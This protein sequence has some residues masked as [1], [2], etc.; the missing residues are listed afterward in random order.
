[1]EPN[2]SLLAWAYWGTGADPALQ[3]RLLLGDLGLASQTFFGTVRDSHGMWWLD[4]TLRLGGHPAPF[5][6]YGPDW[7]CR[8]I[9]AMLLA[10][11]LAEAGRSA[12]LRLAAVSLGLALVYVLLLLAAFWVGFTRPGSPIIDGIQ[13]RYFML[14]YLLLAFAAVS[15]PSPLNA[16]RALARPILLLGLAVQ[17]AVL[18]WA[19]QW[20]QGLWVA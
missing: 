6:V 14:F 7:L 1:V 20:M 18:V 5:S 19:L 16:P 11:T 3:I 12:D 15:L 10:V 8:V 2:L 13:G 4:G 9:L 17:L